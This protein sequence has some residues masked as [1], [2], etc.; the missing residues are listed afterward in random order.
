MISYS[1]NWMGPINMKWIEEHGDYWS[2]GRIDIYGVPG[3][4][5][6]IEYGL[7]VMHTEDWNDFSD[8][9]DDFESKELWE[10]DDIIKQYEQDSDRKIRW[11][12]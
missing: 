8:W 1:T 6:P 10:F 9:L 2:G 7:P 3:E 11:F 4:N 5:Y 12:T